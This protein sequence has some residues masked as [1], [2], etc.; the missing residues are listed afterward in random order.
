M[1]AEIGNPFHKKPPEEIAPL[2]QAEAHPVSER[3]IFSREIEKNLKTYL[4]PEQLIGYGQVGRV[5]HGKAELGMEKTCIK[6]RILKS[7]RALYEN[8]LAEEMQMQDIAHSIL[9][10]AQTP[11]REIAKIP[12][13]FSYFQTSDGE[14]L[15]SME[16]V[17]GKTLYEILIDRTAQRIPKERLPEELQ[18][19]NLTSLPH[20]TLQDIVL[21]HLHLKKE[22]LPTV[23][24]ALLEENA[25]E[26]FLP[27]KIILQLR[28][29]VQELHK[30]R[31]FHRDI[32]LGN[33]M[34]DDS[35]SQCY[36]IDF[37]TATYRKFTSAEEA[38]S[39]ERLGETVHYRRDTD[40][41][42]Q[43]MRICTR[44]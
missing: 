27:K 22:P 1:F 18:N 15:L 14:E 8:S 38:S 30:H 28:S 24:K 40:I 33:I 37:G 31:L 39:V 13:P 41:I 17:H 16:R 10:K 3:T 43:L 25:K 12:R 35:L 34:I 29:A 21:E 26:P 36:L 20:D 2:S 4:E 5:Y 32:H 42:P 9:K 23:W 19:G 44:H 7:G 11:E 6:H